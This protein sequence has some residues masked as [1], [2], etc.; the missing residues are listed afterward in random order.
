MMKGTI[1]IN[2]AQKFGALESDGFSG[3]GVF[4]GV[5]ERTKNIFL[6][7][8][9]TVKDPKNYLKLNN[10]FFFFFNIRLKY[11][12]QIKLI[13]VSWQ[14]MVRCMI[15]RFLVHIP[16][17]KS[18][19]VGVSQESVVGSRKSEVESR[20]PEVENRKSEVVSQKS[21]VEGS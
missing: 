3:A 18:F 17:N 1:N 21:K 14:R 8:L 10:T 7:E 5:E 15:E 19:I 13:S 12:K 16:G 11:V 4:V 9:K 6:I 20:K 2:R